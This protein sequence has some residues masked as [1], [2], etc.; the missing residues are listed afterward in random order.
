MHTNSQKIAQQAYKDVTAVAEAH[1][2]TKKE[3]KKEEETNPYRQKYATMA[4]RLP[5]L[6]HT[7]GLTQ[8]LAFVEA[9]SKKAQAWQL[10]FDHIAQQLGFEKKEDENKQA[11]SAGYWLFKKS[12]EAELELYILLTKQVNDVVVWYKRF[13]ESVLKIDASQ[14]DTELVNEDEEATV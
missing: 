2:N 13:A 1:P 11:Q 10:Y 6:I 12:Q 8:A 14:A 5:I 3:G 4:H 9:K 7:A